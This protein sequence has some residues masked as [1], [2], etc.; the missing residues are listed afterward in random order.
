VSAPT[1]PGA[2]TDAAPD[3]DPTPGGSPRRV[4][5]KRLLVGA[6][7]GL[8][9]LGGGV[10][11]QQIIAADA[12][13]TAAEQRTARTDLAQDV[14]DLR[15]ALA[16]PARTGQTA[17]TALLRHQLE[18]VAGQA[19]DASV[20]DELVAQLRLASEEL[21]D[22][23]RTPMPDR[24]S[25]LPVATVDPVFDRLL[26][27]E[28][29][30]ADL[31]ERLAADADEA[32]AWIAAVR[33]L[34]DAAMT[35]GA[36]TEELPSTDDPDALAAAWR[37]EAERLD[38]YAAAV[39]RAA[40]HEGGAPLADAHGLLVD[41]MRELAADAAGRLEAGDV[42]GY[43]ALLADRLAGDDAFGFASALEPAREEVAEAA[44]D[45]HL[46]ETRARALGLLTELEE[47]RRAA[48]AQLAEL[49]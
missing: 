12:A 2:P 4:T 35:Y 27:L 43:N 22:A 47:L 7:A 19:P 36:S 38:D 6:A 9:A 49:P 42:D 28:D 15:E 39:D 16:E 48:P 41:G 37:A 31:A 32:E 18:L 3:P 30:A 46:E 17:A 8:L 20:G 24:P 14:E 44:I 13:A 21:A 11:M 26:G 33:D 29:Q 34:D 10:G 45:G 40:D 23:A 25:V 1:L 5:R